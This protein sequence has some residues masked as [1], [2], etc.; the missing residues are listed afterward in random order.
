MNN[1]VLQALAKMAAV[2][3]ADPG[4]LGLVNAVSGIMTKQGVSLWSSAPPERP[5]GWH[6]VSEPTAAAT[7]RV[8]VLGDARGEAV[9]ASC[10]ALYD[11]GD[12]PTRA[13]LLADL[14]DGRRV[15]RVEADPELARHVTEEELCGRTVR[16]E[17]G[18]IKI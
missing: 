5:F 17:S 11:A 15:L 10:T 13:V 1:F 3:R 4:A 9:I 14:T 18:R 12:A 6:D 8:E 7:P 16:L 2:L